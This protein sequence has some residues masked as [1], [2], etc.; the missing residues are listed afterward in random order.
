[1][2]VPRFSYPFTPSG[3]TNISLLGGQHGEAVNDSQDY[4]RRLHVAGAY[5]YPAIFLVLEN[6]WAHKS[7]SPA[8]M[9]PVLP[10]T[11]LLSETSSGGTQVT[12]SV[13]TPEGLDA[14]KQQP[15]TTR[16]ARK[17]VITRLIAMLPP[18]VMKVKDRRQQKLLF[19]CW[20]VSW[21][22]ML[23]LLPTNSLT[24][25]GQAGFFGGIASMLMPPNMPISAYKQAATLLIV[26]SCAG[27]AWGCAAIRAAY[28]ARDQA[29]YARTMQQLSERVASSPSL[30]K[31]GGR[32]TREDLTASAYH[33]DFLDNRSTVIFGVFLA[34]GT[35]AMGLL[36]AKKPKFALPAIIATVFL[37]VLCSDGPLFP[38][39]QYSLVNSFVISAAYYIA[40]GL[41]VILFV[42][43]QTLNH[44]WIGGAIKVLDGVKEFIALQEDVLNIEIDGSD[45]DPM[46]DNLR[47]QMYGKASGLSAQFLALASKTDML[48]SEVSYGQLSADDLTRLELPLR[49]VVTR[50]AGLMGFLTIL[51]SHVNTRRS[52]AKSGAATPAS[53]TL[54][55]ANS[56]NEGDTFRLIHTRRLAAGHE[57][58][59]KLRIED[60]MPILRSTTQDLR[61]ACVDAAKAASEALTVINTQRYKRKLPCMSQRLRKVEE[62]EAL[63][64]ARA[65]KN[66]CGAID[67]YKRTHRFKLLQP[68]SSLIDSD[69]VSPLVDEHGNPPFSLRTLFLCFVFQSNLLWA[70][71]A[72]KS[73]LALILEAETK[74]SECQLWWPTSLTRVFEFYFRDSGASRLE[75]MWAPLDV[76]PAEEVGHEF[77]AYGYRKLTIFIMAECGVKRLTQS[78]ISSEKDPDSRPPKHLGQKIGHAVHHTRLW[79]C[80]PETLVSNLKPIASV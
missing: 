39:P 63:D 40:A 64:V 41:F 33:G 27:W 66:L 25:L 72:L 54:S 49:N 36:R 76:P 42:F 77:F 75:T 62:E 38:A 17:S 1:M 55:R 71:D 68:F 47:S 46:N 15:K 69:N 58:H 52:D 37:D 74:R 21:I 45:L 11:I 78:R 5:N 3:G 44:E 53:T 10:P 43:P 28:V 20:L 13:Y 18:W 67:S 14:K 59:Q 50:T 24:I 65:F 23:I 73:L 2:T 61:I 30:S 6:G 4:V 48:H 31:Y 19:R 16:G 29:L 8:Y 22:M 70:A 9:S 26:T 7:N 32:M 60:L 79:L 12:A 35:F 56:L 34:T 51:V 57:F 80:S